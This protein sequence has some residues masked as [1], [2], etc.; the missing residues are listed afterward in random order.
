MTLEALPQLT[1]FATAAS[2]KPTIVVLDELLPIHVRGLADFDPISRLYR[3]HLNPALLSWLRDEMESTFFHECGHV[4]LNHVS[5]GG[6][7]A[8]HK[9]GYLKVV[10]RRKPA[11]Y[12]EAYYTVGAQLREQ[13]ADEE[14]ARLRCTW[15]FNAYNLWKILFGKEVF[16]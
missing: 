4:K 5:T 6:S 3:I 10:N 14:A 11:N 2:A 15:P 12:D 1:G 16:G 8:Q 9:A 7:V 13:A